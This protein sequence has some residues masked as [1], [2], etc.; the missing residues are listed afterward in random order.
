MYILAVN[1]KEDDGAYSV[2]TEDGEQVLYI[3]E[4]EDDATR[5]G[6][7]LEES[8]YPEMQVMEVDD[9]LILSVCDMNEHQYVIITKNDIVIPPELHDT[10]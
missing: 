8:D 4:E 10:V 5:F 6:I 1:G 3:F 9:E 7:M 2:I